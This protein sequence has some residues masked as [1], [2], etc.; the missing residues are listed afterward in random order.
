MAPPTR[1]G[2]LTAV[3]G[4]TSNVISCVAVFVGFG[5]WNC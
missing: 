1:I 3:L 2:L 4:A 5:D